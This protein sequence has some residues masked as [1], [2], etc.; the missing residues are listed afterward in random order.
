MNVFITGGTGNLGEEI[1]YGL[2]RL[3]YSVR[4]LVRQIQ[5]SSSQRL[6]QQEIELC[7]GNLLEPETYQHLIIDADIIVHCAA[8]YT[9]YSQ[10]DNIAVDTF[11][12]VCKSYP[13]K[14]RRL[15]YTSGIMCYAEQTP[16]TKLLTEEDRTLT[17]GWVIRDR[18]RNEQKVLENPFI[19][20]CVIRPAWVYGKTSR[21]FIQYFLKT[22]ENPSTILVTH[23]Q[24]SWSE[25]H[26]DDLVRFYQLVCESDPDLIRSQIFNVSD[27]SQYT[28][29]EI[30]RV[31][32]QAMN[33][34]GELI[35]DHEEKEQSEQWKFCNRTIL[36][37]SS[38][39]TKILG[40][41]CKHKLMLDDVKILKQTC[42]ARHQIL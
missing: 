17:D 21:H 35:E 7:Q 12:A 19:Y 24:I 28:N 30:A 16:T 36:V 20:G 25:I 2:R 29:M 31:Y 42:L 27:H 34:H 13:Y 8:D 37:D 5:A 6:L 23:P 1:S 39:A 18:V 15:L 32:T 26:I 33:W 14:K 22:L 38:K 10:V 4:A 11:L 9:N 40:F 3:G 41:K